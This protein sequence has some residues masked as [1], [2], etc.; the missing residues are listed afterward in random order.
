[1]G[2]IAD[3]VDRANEK[4]GDRQAGHRAEL[5]HEVRSR[6]EEGTLDLEHNVLPYVEEHLYGEHDRLAEFGLDRLRR[7]IDAGGAASDAG[8]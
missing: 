1:M 5:L 7:E 3:V 2:W 4:L 6:R 8:D